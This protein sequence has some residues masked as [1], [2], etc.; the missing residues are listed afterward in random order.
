MNF[1]TGAVKV[2]PAHD[3][4]DYQ[5]GKRNNLEFVSIFSEEGKINSIGG[6][7]EGM[8][9]FDCRIEIEKELDKMGLIRGKKDNDMRLGI[10]SKTN[11][12]IEPFLKPQWY[13]DCKDMANRSCEALRKGDLIIM[14]ESHH[15][16]WYDWLEKIQDW[17]VSRQLWWGHRIPAY[18][19]KVEGV[20][21][22]PDSGNDGHY[23]VGR[24]EEEARKKAA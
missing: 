15:K 3:P 18:L 7:F 6:K 5:C 11:D 4:N 17:C 23:V 19:C 22:N 21:D 10:C 8:M 16:T 14:P 2:T 1:G 12:I 13:I 20:I 9:R 24:T